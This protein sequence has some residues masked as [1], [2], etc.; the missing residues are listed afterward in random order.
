[1]RLEQH[2]YEA[3]RT[4]EPGQQVYF[5]VGDLNSLSATALYGDMDRG[6]DFRAS[7]FQL[8]IH[9][10]SKEGIT[11][12]NL[13]KYGEDKPFRSL[14]NYEALMG[15]VNAVNLGIPKIDIGSRS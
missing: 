6:Y 9:E 11:G 1:M 2:L 15:E 10:D 5:V 4:S 13:K 8:H 3:P 12:A 7:G 14:S